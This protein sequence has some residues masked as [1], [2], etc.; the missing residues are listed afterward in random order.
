MTNTNNVYV[1][2]LA[3]EAIDLANMIMSFKRAVDRADHFAGASAA[4]DSDID[5]ALKYSKDLAGDLCSF[6]DDLDGLN[7][8]L[9]PTHRLVCVTT[10]RE[11]VV[12]VEGGT[13][14]Q[15]LDAA[16]LLIVEHEGG[17]SEHDT[18]TDWGVDRCE[19]I[20]EQSSPECEADT[21]V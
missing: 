8:R 10:K 21:R 18:Q 20:E 2:H 1:Q 14:G 19:V 7:D 17:L 12:R 13:E 15:A 3:Q 4:C 5:E 6:A 9:S 11:Y 16:R